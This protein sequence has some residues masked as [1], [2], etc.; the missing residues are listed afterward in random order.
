MFHTILKI[1][2]STLVAVTSC[3]EYYHFMLIDNVQLPKAY[4]G[5]KEIYFPFIR[6]KEI[7]FCLKLNK[8]Q[9]IPIIFHCFLLKYNIE[10]LHLL[11]HVWMRFFHF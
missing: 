11:F 7:Y 5:K 10:N 3:V 6:L 9:L 8:G 4:N 2:E 1:E